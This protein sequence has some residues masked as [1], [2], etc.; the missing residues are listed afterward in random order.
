M[1]APRCQGYFEI[2]SLPGLIN[3]DFADVR[4]VLQGKGTALM[5]IGCERSNRAVDAAPLPSAV[6]CWKSIL[7]VRPMRLSDSPAIVDITMKEIED[8]IS[9]IRSASSTE[10]DIIHGTGFNM[11]LQGGSCCNRNCDRF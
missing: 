6:R 4:T 7:T 9:E 8:V 5:G 10:I 2:I 1:F 3:V 11:D